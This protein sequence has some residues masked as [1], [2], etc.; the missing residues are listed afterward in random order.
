[1]TCMKHIYQQL[2][3]LNSIIKILVINCKESNGTSENA[4]KKIA[5]IK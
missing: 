2:L 3:T 5:I 1:M 4:T